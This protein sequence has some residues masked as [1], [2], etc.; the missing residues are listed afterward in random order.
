MSNQLSRRDLKDDNYDP[1]IIVS[2]GCMA[3]GNDPATFHGNIARTVFMNLQGPQIKRHEVDLQNRRP[4]HGFAGRRQRR[5]FI[6]SIDG[7]SM[8]WTRDRQTKVEIQN[9]ASRQVTRRRPSPAGGLLRGFDGVCY[10]LDAE[11]GTI[12]WTFLTE[13]EP[14]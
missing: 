3:S 11:T 1:F 10:A 2:A 13:Y 7:I 5:V 4:D 8:L 9:S 12:K 6:G 14:L